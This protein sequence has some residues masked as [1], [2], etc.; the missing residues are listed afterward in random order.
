[1]AIDGLPGAAVGRL[2]VEDRKALLD[3]TTKGLDIRSK[4]DIAETLIDSNDLYKVE[5]ILAGLKDPIRELEL[6]GRNDPG[7]QESL[8]AK[9]SGDVVPDAM[10]AEERNAIATLYEQLRARLEA[11]RSTLQVWAPVEDAPTEKRCEAYEKILEACDP[12]DEAK[13]AVLDNAR[14][15]LERVR[16]SSKNPKEVERINAAIDVTR[17]ERI[18]NRK[19]EDIAGSKR[20]PN[21]R[22]LID[23]AGPIV[24]A[25]NKKKAG[26]GDK[27]N[28][29]ATMLRDGETRINDF[30]NAHGAAPKAKLEFDAFVE[31]VNEAE[32]AAD[33]K[34]TEIAADDKDLVPYLKRMVVP[35]LE[36]EQKRLADGYRDKMPKTAQIEAVLTKIVQAAPFLRSTV[37]KLLTPLKLEGGPDIA[38]IK[39]ALAPLTGHRQYTEKVEEADKL[40]LN[41]LLETLPGW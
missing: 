23:T 28:E 20:I 37:A 19:R 4:L 41:R 7:A 9:L 11:A 35:H 31:S 40:E 36:A 21:L 25:E 24:E 26:L 17:R 33:K 2:P 22:A 1:M 18:F 3:A 10:T 38:A 27:L 12:E 8:G 16:D 32:N 39:L 6:F 29:L 13:V 15:S 30:L 34:I 5:Q 14:K